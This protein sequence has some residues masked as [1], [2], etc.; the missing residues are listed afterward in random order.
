MIFRPE[1]FKASL[2]QFER[3]S[4]RERQTDRQTEKVR[5]RMGKIIFRYLSKYEML[6]SEAVKLVK[7]LPRQ[8]YQGLWERACS[9]NVIVKAY[10]RET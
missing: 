7:F 3:A 5:G 10:F 9:R 4:E 6:F 2:F 1:Y 8:Y